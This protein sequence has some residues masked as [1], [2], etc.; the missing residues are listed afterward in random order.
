[1]A[2]I[3]RVRKERNQS[4]QSLAS[5]FMSYRARIGRQAHSGLLI[6]YR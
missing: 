4:A 1:M 5:V 2:A 6:I 3:Y